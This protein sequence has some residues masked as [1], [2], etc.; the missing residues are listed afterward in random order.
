MLF[1]SAAAGSTYSWGSSINYSL[2][3]AANIDSSVVTI[4]LPPNVVATYSFTV[5]VTDAVTGCV[6][7]LQQTF[8]TT[9]GLN[10]T[11]SGPSAVCE[12]DSANLTVSG[13]SV[14]SWAASPAYAFAD[15]TSASQT[16]F[17][18]VTTLFTING[19]FAGCSQS[20]NYTLT[21]NAKPD[22]IASPIPEI[23]RAHV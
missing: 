20:I 22:A 3:T 1:R 6:N 4:S 11:V 16:I 17:P 21:L 14:Y 15:S 19:T 10:M 9:P 7:T 8:T 2:I 23:G 13:A 18:V 12:G 5:V